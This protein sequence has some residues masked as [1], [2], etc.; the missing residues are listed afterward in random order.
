M[1]SRSRAVWQQYATHWVG[2]GHGWQANGPG[3]AARKRKQGGSWGR[4]AGLFE[5][6]RRG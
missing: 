4:P 5:E 6:K 2:D 3:W 1:D